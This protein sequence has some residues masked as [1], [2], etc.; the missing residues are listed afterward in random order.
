MGIRYKILSG[1]VLMGLMLLISGAMSMYLLT[2]LGKSVSGL[3]QDNYRSIEI[4]KQMLNSLEMENSGVLSVMIGNVDEG[5]SQVNAGREQFDT[6]IKAAMGNLTLSGEKASVDS[7]RAS[8]QKLVELFANLPE[9]AKRQELDRMW[10]VKELNP[11]YNEV[12]KTV[13]VLMTINEAALFT[14]ASNLEHGA[15]RAIMPGIIAIVAGIFL[16]ILFN[17][18]VIHYFVSPIIRITR[19]VDDFVRL[20]VPFDVNV[21]TKDE[22]GKLREA[23]SNLISLVK[24]VQKNSEQGSI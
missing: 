19:G 22:I 15:Y 18:F 5:M 23:I 20:K 11:A 12:A 3:L 9:R 21:E 4:S 7:I 2:T 8:H 10:Y 6:G 16:T 24:K 17:Y 13:K 1:F 14:N